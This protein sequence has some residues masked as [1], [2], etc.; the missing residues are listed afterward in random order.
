MRC[1][2]G[3]KVV[4]SAAC[5]ESVTLQERERDH[6][7]LMRFASMRPIG[8]VCK[9]LTVARRIMTG[10]RWQFAMLS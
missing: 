4:C 10:R 6:K 8:L 2:M 7:K 3:T 9:R 5:V 1:A